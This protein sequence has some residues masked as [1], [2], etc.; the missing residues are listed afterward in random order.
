[1]RAYGRGSLTARVKVGRKE[2]GKEEGERGER[3]ETESW[4]SFPRAAGGGIRAESWSMKRSQSGRGAGKRSHGARRQGMADRSLGLKHGIER[5]S[6]RRGPR[7]IRKDL[8]GP[9]VQMCRFAKH[10]C[11]SSKGQHNYG[12]HCRFA[13]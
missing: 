3:R 13:Y 1:M 6:S 2:G 11:A 9:P 4:K 8:S 12:R 10:S 5:G 7:G